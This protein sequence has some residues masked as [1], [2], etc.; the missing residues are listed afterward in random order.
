MTHRTTVKEILRTFKRSDYHYFEFIPFNLSTLFHICN[1][2][3]SLLPD[4]VLFR[5]A[6]EVLNASAREVPTSL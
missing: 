5:L 3:I 4:I 6:L 1:S 2:P